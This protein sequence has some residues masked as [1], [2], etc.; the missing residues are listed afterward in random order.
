MADLPSINGLSWF[1]V[2][3]MD[4]LP[5]SFISHTQPEPKRPAAAAANCSLNLSRSP[6]DALMASASLPL[7]APPDVAG[8]MISQKNE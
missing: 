3:V 2:L 7:G 5:P 4:S 1:G 8:P 6:N